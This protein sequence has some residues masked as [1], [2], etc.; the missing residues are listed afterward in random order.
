MGTYGNTMT[1]NPRAMDVA[2]ATLDELSGPKNLKPNI[3]ARGEQLVAGFKGLQAETDAIR[4]VEGTGLLI[5]V[6]MATS[7]ETRDA[8]EYKA[9]TMGLNCIHGGD[10]T[11]RYT[12]HFGTTE[13]EADLIVEVTRRVICG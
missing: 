4:D 11:L 2:V 3:S 7:E 1:G 10:N 5:G 13:E 6:S 8:L 12:P 9:R